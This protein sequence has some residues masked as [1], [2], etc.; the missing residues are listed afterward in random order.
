M[1]C[2]YSTYSNICPVKLTA[3]NYCIANSSMAH[4]LSRFP[5]AL[6]ISSVLQSFPLNFT[7]AFLY[8]SLFVSDAGKIGRLEYGYEYMGLNGKLIIT[9]GTEKVHF[10]IAHAINMQMGCMLNGRENCGKTETIKDLAKI[11]AIFSVIR[12]CTEFM[13]F[14]TVHTILV[15][16]VQCGGWGILTNFN[17]MRN[18]VM[19]AISMPIH[20]LNMALITKRPTFQVI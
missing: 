12:N 10:A 11:C 1:Q 13:D 6:G 9:P 7:F 14:K 4:I 17:N 8:N 18:T 19:D 16:L 2:V 20:A 15:G 3:L 5:L